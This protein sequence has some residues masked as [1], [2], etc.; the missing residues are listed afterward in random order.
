VK[1]RPEPRRASKKGRAFSTTPPGAAITN[2]SKVNRGVFVGATASCGRRL[3]GSANGGPEVPR[4]TPARWAGPADIDLRERTDARRRALAAAPLASLPCTPWPCTRRP[5]E[6][7]T[8]VR[9]RAGTSGASTPRQ[10]HVSGAEASQKLSHPQNSPLSE[11][12]P[13]HVQTPHAVPVS[14][15][16]WVIRR[17]A[18]K[19]RESVRETRHRSLPRERWVS[20]LR[21]RGLCGAHEVDAHHTRAACVDPVHSGAREGSATFAAPWPGEELA[22]LSASHQQEHR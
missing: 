4:A 5:P 8:C 11:Q 19:R 7:L 3:A 16:A 18:A 15:R 21:T 1:R 9:W 13:K 6:R 20:F 2:A 12:P 14:S 10:V 22:G 17:V